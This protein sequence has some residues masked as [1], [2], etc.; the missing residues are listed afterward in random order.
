MTWG[1]GKYDAEAEELMLR[2]RARGLVLVVI[3]GDRGFGCSVKSMAT[4]VYPLSEALIMIA[5]QMKRDMGS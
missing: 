3:E 4:D 2:L 5:E 1:P